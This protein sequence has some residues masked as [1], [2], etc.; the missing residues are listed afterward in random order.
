M[1]NFPP[2]IRSVFSILIMLIDPIAGMMPFLLRAGR[3]RKLTPMEK[4]QADFKLYRNSNKRMTNSELRAHIRSG[5]LKIERSDAFL[6]ARD[7][8]CDMIETDETNEDGKAIWR[9]TEES[10]ALLEQWTKVY[11][12]GYGSVDGVAYVCV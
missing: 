2:Y 6:I 12:Q 9:R 7:Y 11:E 10:Q 1:I 8:Y 4:L 3:G 5:A